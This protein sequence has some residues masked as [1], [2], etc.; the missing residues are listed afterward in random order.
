M[1]KIDL[2]KHLKEGLSLRKISNLTG[3]SL[4]TIRYWSVK[5]QLKPKECYDK[6]NFKQL[7]PLIDSSNSKAEILE[8]MGLSL[9]AGNY[10]T[11][12][13]YFEKY[14]IDND[15]YKGN[16]K[17]NANRVKYSDSEVFCKNS[18]Y[19]SAHLKNRVLKSELLEYKCVQCGNEGEWNGK[20]LVLQIDHINGVNTDNRI[21]NLR[22]MC[23]NCHSQTET[24]SKGKLK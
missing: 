11:L 21:D 5:Y 8:K 14:N 10:G 22:F 7:K 17:R 9:N 3:K 4:T 16:I 12:K 19:N 18:Q 23:P 1:E 15:L 6:W 2:E 20:K 24:F 13:R